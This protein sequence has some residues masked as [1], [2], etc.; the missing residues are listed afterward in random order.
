MGMLAKIRR[1]YIREKLSIRE[2]ARQTHL[3]RNTVRQ[4][5]KHA[6]MREPKYATRQRVSVVDPYS[7]Q[8]RS[9][10]ETDSHRPKRDRRTAKA[11]FEAIKAS[12]YAGSYPR[13]SVYVRKLKQV[14][15]D[16][17]HRKAFVPLRFAHGEAFQFDWSCEYGWIGRLRRRLEVSHCKLACS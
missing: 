8:L 11:M 10:L 5:L 2:I 15:S 17:P 14:I 1:M 7:D 16:C 9:W 3:S 13:V 12:G 4:W 6:E